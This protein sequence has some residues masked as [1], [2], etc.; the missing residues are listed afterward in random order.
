MYNKRIKKFSINA[1]FGGS[2]RTQQSKKIQDRVDALM[3]PDV[4]SLENNAAQI[5]ATTGYNK[6]TKE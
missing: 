1:N 5:K 2:V 3:Q 4:K 6:K